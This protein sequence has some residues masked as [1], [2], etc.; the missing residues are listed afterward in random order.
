M[1][2]LFALLARL[3]AVLLISGLIVRAAPVIAQD[4][5]LVTLA[6]EAGFDGYFRPEQWMPVQIRVGN[7]GDDVIGRLVVRPE[8][9]GEGITNTFSAPVNLPSGA[10]QSIFLYITARAFASQIRVEMINDAGVVIASQTAAIRAARP[11]D[12]LYAAIVGSAAG[13]VDMTG[14]RIGAYDAF[15]ADWTTADLPDRGLALDALDVLL[16]SDVDTAAFNP[17]QQQ[18]LRDW[19]LSGGHLIV[20]GGVNWAAAAAGLRDLLPLQPA[21]TE[22][23]DDLTPLAA[24]IGPREGPNALRERTIIAVGELTPDAQVLVE[25]GGLPLLARRTIG[26]GVVDYL[27]ADPATRPLRGWGLLPELWFTLQTTRPPQP[28]WAAGFTNWDQAARAAEI[29]PGFDPLPDILPL[30]LFLILY[31]ALI[32]PVNYIVLNRLNK[33]EWAWVTIPAMIVI[34]SGL[35]YGFG[36]NLRGSDVTLN[37]LAVVQSWPETDRAR[38]DG[39]IGLLSPRRGQYTL[40][41]AADQPDEILRPI[42]QS[43]VTGNLLT[44]NVQAS[45]D[46]QQAANFAATNFSVDASFV[47]GFNISGMV[48]KPAVSGRAALSYDFIEGQQLVRGSVRNDADYTIHDPV[49][50]A[51]GVAL[52]LNAPLEPG[53]IEAFDLVLPGEG[54][55]T[56]VPYIPSPNQPYLLSRTSFLADE[57]EQTARDILGTERYRAQ[58]SFSLTSSPEEQAARRMQLF[59]NALIDDSYKSTGRGD[60]VYLAGWTDQMPL[61]IDLGSTGWTAQTTTLLLIKLAQE[62]TAPPASEITISPERFGWVT[63]AYI[64]LGEI[65]PVELSMQPGDQVVFRFTPLPD[66]VLKEVTQLRFRLD[67]INL[68]GRRI[69]IELWDWTAQTWVA[70]E[71]GGQGTTVNDFERFLGPQ[72]AVQVR[73]VADEIGGFLRLGSLG[74]EQAGHL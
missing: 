46:I 71:I 31:I 50:L 28:G 45:I 34:F 67:D 40:A 7:D 4:A 14:A 47:A 17:L 61:E 24:W 64:G 29:L 42:P 12:R 72:N 51:R 49:I 36:L 66:A 55:P 52:R 23:V 13:S 69:P 70:R 68:T 8:T 22:S 53:D 18:A 43:L 62:E 56:R 3:L 6:V 54:R 9:S 1:M 41:T 48:E 44:R 63:Q 37:Q 2:R 16:I 19:V 21:R 25:R 32:G 5:P 39:V 20:A 30:I 11:Q 73:L 58:F 74:I 27:A 35:A 26:A 15:Q 33:R 59:L 57:A 10:R 60:E 38:A 65:T